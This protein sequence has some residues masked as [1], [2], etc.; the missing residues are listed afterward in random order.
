MKVAF[1]I[2]VRAIDSGEILEF[3]S[4][5][6]LQSRLEKI[7]VE[8]REYEAWDST[9][10]PFE[11][12]LQEC[13]WIRFA[14]SAQGRDSEQLRQA[15]FQ[16]AKSVGVELPEDL[17]ISAFAKAFN[18]VSDQNERNMLAKS[19]IRRLFTRLRK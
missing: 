15:L 14:P 12:G 4:V 17:P 19:S 9:G 13:V 10:L 6:E 3:D 16:F 2:F 1:P 5:Y 8:N 18:Q 7:D 11:L